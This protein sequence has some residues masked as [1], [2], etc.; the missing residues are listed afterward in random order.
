[1]IRELIFTLFWAV[2]LTMTLLFVATRMLS[3]GL[4][5]TPA[6]LRALRRDPGLIAR[7]L[8]ANFV[9]VPALGV[10]IAA[11][12]WV[13]AQAAL[14]ILLLAMLGGGVDFLAL[15]EKSNG[16]TDE[17]PPLVFVLSFVGG[18]LSPIVRLAIQPI[19]APV[20]GSVWGLLAVTML[21]VPL[22]LVAGL[23]FRRA[24][25]AAAR[26]LSKAMALVAVLL[27]VVAAM[28]TF[29]VKAPLVA[30]IGV[31]GAL[32][33]VVLIAGAAVAGWLLG[34]PSGQHRALLA[35]TTIMRNV[36]LSL[37]LAIVA[38]PDA[39]VDVAVLLF[40]GIEVSLR[41]VWLLIGSTAVSS[42]ATLGSRKS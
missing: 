37:L 21:V 6:D 2:S 13:P 12:V 5:V 38:F 16:E 10:A 19:G 35:R 26:V 8:I 4:S 18:L 27:F 32:A 23:L 34:G 40:A 28:T 14:A 39:G 25:P 1:V 36:G 33:M 7:A 3:I 22:P 42:V 15:G 31:K 11:M 20:M 30:E 9:I 24:A 41:L 29:V 17:G